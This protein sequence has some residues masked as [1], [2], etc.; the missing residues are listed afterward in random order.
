MT[1][2]SG[3]T[4]TDTRNAAAAADGSVANWNTTKAF[5]G[6][7]SVSGVVFS[8]GGGSGGGGGGGVVICGCGGV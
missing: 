4:V 2:D 7:I 1:I 5:S 3:V 6:S 8:G